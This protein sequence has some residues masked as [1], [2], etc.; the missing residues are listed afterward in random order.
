MPVCASS[1]AGG[2]SMVI[3]ARPSRADYYRAL[4]ETLPADALVVT[5]LGNASYL[6]AV[7]R[8]APENF[9]FEDAMGLALPLALG[10]AIA[11]PTRRVVVVG[12]SDD[13]YGISGHRRRGGAEQSDRVADSDRRP[14]RFGRAGID[15]PG[16]R[17]RAT[18]PC[19]RYRPCKECGDAG[20]T[21]LGNG[22]PLCWRRFAI[23]RSID[24][25]RCRGR[26]TADCA[27]SSDD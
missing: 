23:S 4:A 9:Y 6:W 18:C 26:S 17:S 19:G 22:H 5:S 25:T 7:V 11:Q 15:E 2:R 8:H 24:Q 13:A 21:C 14:C 1:V 20:G 10:L 3:D 16:A 12:R 27:R